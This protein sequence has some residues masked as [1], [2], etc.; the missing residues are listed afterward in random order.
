MYNEC[1]NE[2][3]FSYFELK[4]SQILPRRT[5]SLPLVTVGCEQ[6]SQETKSDPMAIGTF[7]CHTRPADTNGCEKYLGQ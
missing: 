2:L 4:K 7:A 3:K 6:F 1:I 5:V